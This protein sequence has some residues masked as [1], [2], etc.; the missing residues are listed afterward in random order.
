MCP[1]STTRKPLPGL[2]TRYGAQVQQELLSLLPKTGFEM[3]KVL[4]YHMGWRNE[5]G[6]TLES[7]EGQGKALRPALCL[8]AC[9]ALGGDWNKALPAAAALE[10]IHN[11][12]LIHDDIQDGDIERRHRPT[13]WYLWGPGKALMSGDAMHCLAYQTS[14]RLR[15]QGIEDERALRVS[16]VLVES[17]LAMIEGQSMDLDFENNLAISQDQYLEMIR[18]KTGALITCS[19]R[20]GALLGSQEVAHEVGFSEYGARL[21]RIFQIK[22]DMLGIWGDES[23]TGKSAGNDIRRRK[24]SYPIVYAFE[25]AAPS[26]RTEMAAIYEKKSLSEGDVERVMAV[27]EESGA[28]RHAQSLIESEA[29]LGVRALEG[30]PLHDWAKR[31]AE[32]L[33]EFL[34]N[35]EY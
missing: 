1:S 26:S 8:F 17:S 34:V 25:K 20:L 12:S 4:Q 33:I 22:D 7:P 29:A 2:F 9:H 27:L 30:L 24:K 15:R 18:L 21:G 10:L 28:K 5:Q 19:L 6:E 35:R 31:E 11:F 32:E 16:Q 23:K 14:M 3:D 13:V